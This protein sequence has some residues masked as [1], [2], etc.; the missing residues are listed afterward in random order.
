MAGQFLHPVAECRQTRT[1]LVTIG[2]WRE[3]TEFLE[4][5]IMAYWVRVLC[6]PNFDC[7]CHDG[8]EEVAG[9]FFLFLFLFL[10]LDLPVCSSKYSSAVK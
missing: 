8:R 7:S 5:L 3:A 10:F 9:F 4:F 1:V 6:G 2:F